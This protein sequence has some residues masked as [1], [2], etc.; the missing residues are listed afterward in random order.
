MVVH[1][2]TLDKIFQYVLE[3]VQVLAQERAELSLRLYLQCAMVADVCMMEKIAYEFLAQAFLLYEEEI[4]DSKSQLALQ[5]LIVGTLGK[6]ANLS[7]ENYD[8]LSTKTC[9]YS[10]KLLKK[11]DQCRAAHTCSHLFWTPG[12]ESHM[13]DDRVLECLQRSL[14]LADQCMRAQQTPLFVEILNKYLYHFE[15]ENSKVCVLCAYACQCV[16]HFFFHLS[17]SICRFPQRS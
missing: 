13:N 1:P 8:T 11:P 15:Q 17:A 9:Q 2:E 16:W 12:T 10:A 3:I 5:Q 14:K 7:E 6:M 4:T